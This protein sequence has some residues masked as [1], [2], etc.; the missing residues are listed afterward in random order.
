[1]RS[2]EL[3]LTDIGHGVH[4]DQHLRSPRVEGEEEDEAAEVNVA[5]EDEL[6]VWFPPAG[7]GCG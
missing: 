6:R 1:M 2:D 4:M 5:V 3:G 7:G